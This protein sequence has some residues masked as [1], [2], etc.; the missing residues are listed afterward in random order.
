MRVNEFDWSS[1]YIVDRIVN[2]CLS[3]LI[4]MPNSFLFSSQFCRVIS[5]NTVNSEAAWKTVLSLIRWLR[6]KPDELDL[7]CFLMRNYQDGSAGQGSTSAQQ[8]NK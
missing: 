7:H 8:V 6:Q 5:I 1:L 3:D 2:P 4:K